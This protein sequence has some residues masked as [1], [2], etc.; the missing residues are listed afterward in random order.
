MHWGALNHR[1]AFTC[2]AEA[3]APMDEK[4]GKNQELPT[5]LH[6]DACAGVFIGYKELKAL[7]GKPATPG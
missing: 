1:G 2:F 3:A 4:P 5:T 7:G 6:K